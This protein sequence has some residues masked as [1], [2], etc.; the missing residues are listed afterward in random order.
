[1]L[2]RYRRTREADATGSADRALRRL[3]LQA[4]MVQSLEQLRGC[5][6]A[7]PRPISAPCA[8]CWTQFGVLP[9]GSGGR[10][11][12]RSMQCFP[13]STRCFS[14]TSTLWY[15]RRGFNPG[16]GFLHPMREDMP[17]WFPDLMEEFRAVLADAVV[18]PPVFERR[19]AAPRLRIHGDIL[20]ALP[21]GRDNTH[22]AYPRL[23]GQ[24]E[25]RHRQSPHRHPQRLPPPDRLSGS[26]FGQGGTRRVALPGDGVQMKKAVGDRLR[27]RRSAAAAAS[28]ARPGR[29][30]YACPAQRLRVLSGHHRAANAPG[31]NR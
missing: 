14:V 25:Q 3:T 26:S 10:H 5:E 2:R 9:G 8:R 24:G 16:V 1:M 18:W 11:P 23:R 30:R 15:A 27:Y 17:R 19:I 12:I 13:T 22:P 28:R 20:R 7:Q 4:K 21:D 31:P 29:I 6:G